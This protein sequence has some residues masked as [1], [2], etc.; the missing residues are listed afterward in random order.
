M[1]FGGSGA[2][3]SGALNKTAP[4][5]GMYVLYTVDA[6]T[7]IPT[8]GATTITTGGLVT[9]GNT[10][11]A[12]KE[13]VRSQG[14]V[15]GLARAGSLVPG[16]LNSAGSTTVFA[17]TANGEHI[18][19]LPFSAG[20]YARAVMLAHLDK[21]EPEH[22]TALDYNPLATATVMPANGAVTLIDTVV[23]SG[24]SE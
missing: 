19:G 12:L 3:I 13:H 10:L 24:A 9:D 4:A 23:I 1:L 8:V 16:T 17:T 14:A 2:F 5:N 20:Y 21:Y 6:T 11:D 22:D 18:C 7:T 15:M